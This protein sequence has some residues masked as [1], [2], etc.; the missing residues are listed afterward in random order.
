MSDIA[1]E[2]KKW[3]GTILV[4]LDKKSYLKHRA[5][6]VEIITAVVRRW[7]IRPTVRSYRPRS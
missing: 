6:E 4:V 1:R 2:K 7:D 3:E 5:V